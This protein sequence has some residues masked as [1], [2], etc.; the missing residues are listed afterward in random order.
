MTINSG[1]L[2][3][4]SRVLLF[5]ACVV[6]VAAARVQSPSGMPGYAAP[7]AEAERRVEAAAIALPSA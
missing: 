1:F 2:M 7:G 4:A 5:G 6:G 3:H